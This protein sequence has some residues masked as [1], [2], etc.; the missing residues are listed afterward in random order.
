MS[1]E[2]MEMNDIL[3][4]LIQR[5]VQAES[6]FRRACRQIL[7]L[8]R[9][10]TDLQ[11]RYDMSIKQNARA[12]RYSLRVRIAVLEGVRN[13]YFEYASMKADLIVELRKQ[14]QQEH[15]HAS[16]ALDFE[17]DEDEA[18]QEYYDEYDLSDSELEFSDIDFSDLD[19]E[20]L[21]ESGNSVDLN[22]SV[23][24]VNNVDN[25]GDVG[26]NTAGIDVSTITKQRKET[27]LNV[28]EI[29]LDSG[30]LDESNIEDDI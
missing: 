14:I 9:F 16:A 21:E 18:N 2:D 1:A 22:F 26:M 4:E 17:D 23:L 7:V 25:V 5:M 15:E 24:V 19:D 11:F 13:M 29:S 20:D 27:D 30:Y 28:M 6:C 12:F 10:I 3:H 8:N